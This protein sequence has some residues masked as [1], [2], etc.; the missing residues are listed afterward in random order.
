MFWTFHEKREAK[1]LGNHCKPKRKKKQ[2]RVEQWGELLMEQAGQ[3]AWEKKCHLNWQDTPRTTHTHTPEKHDHQRFSARHVMNDFTK[4]WDR[5][6]QASWH[7]THKKQAQKTGPMCLGNHAATDGDRGWSA[8]S[9]LRIESDMPAYDTSD[10]C[11]SSY[12]ILKMFLWLY[13]IVW[14]RIIEGL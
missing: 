11:D 12:C 9:K 3:K 1:K 14:N 2:K 5:S 4:E 7:S 13:I 8:G 10:I 6:S